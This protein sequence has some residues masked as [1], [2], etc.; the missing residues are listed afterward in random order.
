MP[1]HSAGD[2]CS[3]A[4]RGLMLRH[5]EGDECSNGPG[6]SFVQGMGGRGRNLA[7]SPSEELGKGKDC[8]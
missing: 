7:V 5:S 4:G 6:W 3:T 1:R 2:E 8:G